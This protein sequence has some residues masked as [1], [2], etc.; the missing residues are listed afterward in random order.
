MKA[1]L[2]T[3]LLT[4]GC[5]LIDQRTFNPDAGMPPVVARPVV[6]APKTMVGP[7]P[8]ITIA[9]A[10]PAEFRAPLQKAVA[11][12]R[13]RKADVVFD[14]VEMQPPETVAAAGIGANAE[15]V[16]KLITAEGV[17]PGRV[18]LAVRPEED[19]RPNEV[20]VYVR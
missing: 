6:K 2:A 1:W 11:A 13:A 16:A 14:V 9:T 5:T 4:A 20:R 7:P 10:N 19:V 8:L 12:A 3:L 15:A 18:R 17:P